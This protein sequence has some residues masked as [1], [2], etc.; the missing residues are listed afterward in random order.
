MYINYDF[1]K[2]FQRFHFHKITVFLKQGS[3]SIWGNFSQ[4]FQNDNKITNKCTFLYSEQFWPLSSCTQKWLGFAT[5][6]EPG[7][8]E[9]TCSLTRLYTIYWPTS[10][11][12]LDIPKKEIW[13]SKYWSWIIPF[14]KFS[15]LRVKNDGNLSQVNLEMVIY[16]M[17]KLLILYCSIPH[18]HLSELYENSVYF[19]KVQD[20]IKFPY[21]QGE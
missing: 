13:K 2:G 8:N 21:N 16:D 12:Y 6:I 14:K 5:S 11:S 9:H 7:Q 20:K 10:S 1:S 4:Q 15:R 19:I 18:I 3:F 17:L